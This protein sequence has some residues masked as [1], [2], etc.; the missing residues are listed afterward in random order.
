MK[1]MMILFAFTVLFSNCAKEPV[2]QSLEAV[3]QDLRQIENVQPLFSFEGRS[4]SD[5]LKCHIRTVHIQK[6]AAIREI[7]AGAINDELQIY[8]STVPHDFPP[9]EDCTVMHEIGFDIPN[10]EYGTYNVTVAINLSV[11]KISIDHKNN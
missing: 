7:T 2:I 8:V 10:L 1:K 9:C 11:D 3:N 4:V 6:N 5:T